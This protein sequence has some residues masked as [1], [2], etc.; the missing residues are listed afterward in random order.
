MLVLSL[1]KYQV[2]I[3]SYC[4]RIGRRNLAPPVG[5]YIRLYLMEIKGYKIFQYSLRQGFTLIELLVV[6]AIIGLLAAVVLVSMGPSRAAARDSRRLAE[7]SQLQ[8]ALQLRF[9]DK[10]DYPRSPPPGPPTWTDSCSNP[11]NWLPKLVNEGYIGILPVD[12]VN[13]GNICYRYRGQGE[14]FKLAVLMES[15][16]DKQQYAAQDGGVEAEWYELFTAGAKNW[17]WSP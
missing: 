4:S 11:A 10:D 14:D 15:D 9:L 13:S 6:I 7:A 12:P 3:L 8:K 5:I 16:A 17:T 2:A 1:S